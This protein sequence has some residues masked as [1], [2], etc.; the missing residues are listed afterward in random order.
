MQ[1]FFLVLMMLSIA[2]GARLSKE[3]RRLHEYNQRMRKMKER[4]AK[5]Q[6][7]FQSEFDARLE[8]I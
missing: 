7:Q 5:K 8:S 6:D 3:E 2:F 1:L 4:L